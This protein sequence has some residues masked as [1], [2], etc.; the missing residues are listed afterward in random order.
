MGRRIDGHGID[1]IGGD[2]GERALPSEGLVHDRHWAAELRSAIACTGSFLGLLL[3]VDAAAGTFSPARVALWS[4]LA[5]LLFLV[6]VPPRVTAAEGWLGV[7]G[8]WRTRLVRTDRLVSVRT[9]GSAGQRLVLRDALGGRIE[10]DPRVLTANP[11]LWHR[12][13]TDMR[14]SVSRGPCA[15]GGPRW[16]GCRNAWTAK[17]RW[18]SSRY[19]AWRSSRAVRQPAPWL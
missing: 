2:S 1:G 10:F 19:L 12:L 14:I 13:D 3:L 4:G 11:L 17:R 16:T 5:L 18:R 7:R 8:P 6:L 9:T 15:R